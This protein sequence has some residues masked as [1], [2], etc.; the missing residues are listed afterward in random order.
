MT[1]SSLNPYPYT[2][3][4]SPVL[5]VKTKVKLGMYFSTHTVGLGKGSTS[6]SC[7]NLSLV[8]S[9]TAQDLIC[10]ERHPKDSGS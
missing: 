3:P 4:D 6:E 8:L 9:L 1:V 2:E 7:L 10:G 5:T